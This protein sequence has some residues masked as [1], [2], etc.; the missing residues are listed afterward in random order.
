A[1][2]FDLY[3]MIPGFLA[4]F[5]VTVVVSLLTQPPPEAEEEFDAVWR[6][7]RES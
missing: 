2:V 4:G 7:V 6:A 3:E 1:R 5:V